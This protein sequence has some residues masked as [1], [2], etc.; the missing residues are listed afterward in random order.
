VRG[1]EGSLG[2]GRDLPGR[3]AWLCAGSPECVVRAVTRRALERALRGPVTA[4]ALENLADQ[5]AATTVA[6]TAVVAGTARSGER[7]NRSPGAAPER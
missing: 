2:V 1:P 6:A 7:A 4:A 3:G 5:L